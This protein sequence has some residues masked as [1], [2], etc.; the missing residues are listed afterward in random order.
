MRTIK[1][2]SENLSTMLIKQL[3][4]E[5][6]NY[7]LYKSFANYYSIEGIED[8]SKYYLKRADE[9]LKHHDWIYDYLTEADIKFIYPQ[10]EANTNKTDN[11]IT[12]F[13]DTVEREIETTDLI[14]KIYIAAM[15]EKDFM[16][17]TWLQDLLIKE[18]S[19]E[20]NTS[21]QALAI[22]EEN[23]DIFN[24]AEKVLELLG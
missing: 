22:M 24:K 16:T 7:N 8:L 10:V 15:E 13:K 4:H 19:E 14:Y 1:S 12:P 18:Q 21:R 20:E 17:A 9:E 23:A 5:L 11:Y 2:I 6:K 3:A